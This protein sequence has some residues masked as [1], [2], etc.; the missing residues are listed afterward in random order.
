MLL[1]KDLLICLKPWWWIRIIWNSRLQNIISKYTL[2]V[3]QVA[4]QSRQTKYLWLSLILCPSRIFFL[5]TKKKN[6]FLVSFFFF[7]SHKVVSLII[8]FIM[9][10]NLFCLKWMLLVMYQRRMTLRKLRRTEASICSLT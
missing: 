8:Q 1:K 5:K 2:W 4:I 3:P 6:Y 9:I 10:Y 7:S